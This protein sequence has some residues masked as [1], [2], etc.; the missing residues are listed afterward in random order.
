MHEYKV[1]VATPGPSLF[2]HLP[3]PLSNSHITHSQVSFI[4]LS[5]ANI[6]FLIPGG[7]G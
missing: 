4:P 2:G 7:E 5:F 1:R 6:S 3:P